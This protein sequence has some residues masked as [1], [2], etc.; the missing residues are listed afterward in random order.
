VLNIRG[1]FHGI[2]IAFPRIDT[3]GQNVAGLLSNDVFMKAVDSC[4]V[5]I[6]ITDLKANILY[7]NQAFN[8]ITGYAENELIGHN[9]SI[10]SNHT[11]PSLVYQTLWGRLSQKKPW[12]GVL[13]NRRKDDSLYLA[14][15]TVAPV[16]SKIVDRSSGGF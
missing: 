12:I 11:T 4:P 13:V 2:L 16:I 1:V 3:P 14:E 10:L 9:E 5:G 8:E 7:A 6:S 15:L